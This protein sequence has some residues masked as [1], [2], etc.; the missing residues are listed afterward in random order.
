[1]DKEKLCILYMLFFFFLIS[2]STACNATV[3]KYVKNIFY[4]GNTDL[5]FSG[6]S[7]HNRFTYSNE[8]IK[9]RNYNELAWGGGIGRGFLDRDGDWQAFYAIGFLDSHKYFEPA[10]GYVFLKQFSINN[11]QKHSFGFGFS[12]LLTQRPDILDGYPVL[13]AVPIVNVTFESLGFFAAY[14]P[15]LGQ[16]VGNVLFLFLKFYL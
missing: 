10:L 5:Y 3:A 4:N 2:N 6:Y 16:N 1:M 11:N 12:A 9:N 13:G 8:N 14:V 15:G 7:W